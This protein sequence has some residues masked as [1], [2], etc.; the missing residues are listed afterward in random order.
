LK[1]RAFSATAPGGFGKKTNDLWGMHTLL[2][3]ISIAWDIV[4]ATAGPEA[5]LISTAS[6]FLEPSKPE[7]VIKHPEGFRRFYVPDMFRTA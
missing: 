3:L 7:N 6:L 1:A 4:F 5:V 2:W